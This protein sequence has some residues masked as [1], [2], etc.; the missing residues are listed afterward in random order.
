M[1]L[2]W[3]DK[4]IITLLSTTESSTCIQVQT[5]RG[6]LKE[7]P[8]IVKIYSNNMLGVDKMHQLATYV[9]FF[10]EEVGQVVEE[11]PVLAS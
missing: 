7:L 5:C 2:Q 1:A 9:L 4:R 8:K 6:Q 11:V 10:S 3:Q